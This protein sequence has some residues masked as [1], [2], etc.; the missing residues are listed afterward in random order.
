[1]PYEYGLYITSNMLLVYS[2]YLQLGILN[3][4]NRDYPQLLGIGKND[5]AKHMKS[6]VITFLSL[7]Y[8]VA[9]VLAS[10]VLFFLYQRGVMAYRLYVSLLANT[11]FAWFSVC[12]S[13]WDN[14]LRSEKK[15]NYVSFV[16]IVKT[17]ILIGF[18][19]FLVPRLKYWGLFIAVG[20]SLVVAFLL[21][22]RYIRTLRFTW[23]PTLIF[24]LMRGGFLLLI[25]SLV[26]TLM[27][28]IDKF[29]ILFFMSYEELGI[30]SVA[31]L[32]FST[33]VLI[34]QSISS[35]LYVKAARR[36]GSHQDKYDLV[37]TVNIY[38]F[39]LSIVTSVVCIGAYYI[40]PPFI[41]LAMP[42]YVGGVRPAQMLIMG[43]GVYSSSMLFGNVFTLLKKNVI[44]IKNTIIL[45]ILNVI[46]SSG[47]VLLFGKNILYVA[48]GTTIAYT[49]YGIML[50]VTLPRISGNSILTCLINSVFPVFIAIVF[51]Q[52]TDLMNFNCTVK[53]CIAAFSY[54][55]VIFLLFKKRILIIAK[56]S[57][58][59]PDKN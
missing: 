51:L 46:L 15:F 31:L 2:N 3:S 5:E 7:F 54:T 9:V 36:Y 59:S 27:M 24:S 16:M 14:T 30:Y 26:W 29:I 8:A 11:V 40:L 17:I 32:G 58:L 28:S 20:V 12:T 57:M 50:A 45:C 42:D 10:A 41:K 39:V 23:D 6:A 55:T 38:T 37:E 53:M 44:V 25:N 1:M 52:L 43:V 34:P 13:F 33:L 19:L 48:I 35:V 47:F 22:N 18:G 21:D 4:Y 49:L 56:S